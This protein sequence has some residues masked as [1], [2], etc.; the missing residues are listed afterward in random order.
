M[1]KIKSVRI[2]FLRKAKHSKIILFHEMS[3]ANFK[4]TH[5]LFILHIT[6]YRRDAN[7]SSSN[8]ISHE[9]PK[10]SDFKQKDFKRTF[11]NA[12]ATFRQVWFDE[13]RNDFALN[14]Y[15]VQAYKV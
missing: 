2:A 11:Y 1:K 13:L 10:S 3:I 9:N 4:F 14:V 6:C 8:N 7:I 15:N 12:C 5:L